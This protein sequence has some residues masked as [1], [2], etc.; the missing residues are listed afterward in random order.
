ML[1]DKNEEIQNLRRKY[2]R[3]VKKDGDKEEG[4]QAASSDSDDENKKSKKDQFDKVD[5]TSRA[6]IKNVLLKYL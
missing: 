4:D 1:V 3:K 5:G 6:Y 2:G